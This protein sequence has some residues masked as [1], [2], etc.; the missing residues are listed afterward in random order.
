MN[1]SLTGQLTGNWAIPPYARAMLWIETSDA[2]VQTQGEHGT[3]A[4]PSPADLVTLRWG[5]DAP[6]A[7]SLGE[8]ERY[9]VGA[10][11][12]L[13]RLRW[14]ADALDW[15][16]QVRIGGYIDTMHITPIS[17]LDDERALVVLSVGGMP[18]LPSVQPYPDAAARRNVPYPFPAFREGMAEDVPETITTWLALDDSPVLTLAQDALVSK[19]RVYV[20]GRLAD[21]RAGW[22]KQFALP[23]LLESMTLFAP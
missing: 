12:A 18:L 10:G 17:G 2:L 21:E 4:L 7:A 20:F 15:D 3:F 19:L 14:K 9:E 11:T 13:A 1:D 22:H 23:L 8:G 6:S 5:N 16:G